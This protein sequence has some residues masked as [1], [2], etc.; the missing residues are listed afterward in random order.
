MTT[1]DVKSYWPFDIQVGQLRRFD[2]VDPDLHPNAKHYDAVYQTSIETN[3]IFK[4]GKVLNND[5][6]VR[7]GVHVGGTLNQKQT[8]NNYN[9]MG[10][11]S[12]LDQRTHNNSLLGGVYVH[13]YLLWVNVD[14][15][16][17]KQ[18]NTTFGLFIPLMKSNKCSR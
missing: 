11:F 18:V 13:Y 6:E 4:F 2:Y 9:D 12:L 16:T 15:N 10:G 5:N 7:V 1:I 17:N 14:F 3:Y 8:F